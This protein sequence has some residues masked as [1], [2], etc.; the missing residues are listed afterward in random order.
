MHPFKPSL[1]WPRISMIIRVDLADFFAIEAG[2]RINVDDQ[3]LLPRDHLTRIE[4]IGQGIL[5]S[6]CYLQVEPAEV[7][8]GR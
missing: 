7:G 1:T 8:Q 4:D 5:A 3:N 6:R 2:D